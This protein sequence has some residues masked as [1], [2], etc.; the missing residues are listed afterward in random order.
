MDTSEWDG[1]LCTITRAKCF[2]KWAGFWSASW[3]STR[4]TWLSYHT[5]FCK[6]IF[7][8]FCL[9]L[10]VKQNLGLVM[11]HGRHLHPQ[12]TMEEWKYN[13]NYFYLFKY[14]RLHRPVLFWWLWFVFF[15]TENQKNYVYVDSRLHTGPGCKKQFL[16]LCHSMPCVTAICCVLVVRGTFLGQ[17]LSREMHFWLWPLR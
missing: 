2:F 1:C 7:C 5:Q 17:S 13:S 10:L 4:N 3:T 16:I 11:V 9:T 6:I 15:F 12:A 14:N 8:L